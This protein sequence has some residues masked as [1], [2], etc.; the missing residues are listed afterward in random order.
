[1]T[2]LSVH[3]PDSLAKKA[4]ELARTDRISMDQF[5]ALAVAEKLSAWLTEDYLNER[6]KRGSREKFLAVLDKA[7]DVEPPEE[8]RRP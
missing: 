5:I 2:T 4:E 1:M 7:P 3:L 8:D 6:A